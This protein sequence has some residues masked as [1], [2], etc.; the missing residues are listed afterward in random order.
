MKSYQIAFGN[1]FTKINRN[2]RNF[3]VSILE[4]LYK[5]EKKLPHSI[6]IGSALFYGI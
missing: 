5:D 4:L 3:A 6:E 1:L 2:S